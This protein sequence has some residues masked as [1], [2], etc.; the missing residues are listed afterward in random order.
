MLPSTCTWLRRII[1]NCPNLYSFMFI[2]IFTLF[3]LQIIASIATKR[4]KV[5]ACSL[6]FQASLWM[7]SCK[8]MASLITW[9]QGKSRHR[10]ESS[11]KFRLGQLTWREIFLCFGI[12]PSRMFLSK[13]NHRLF[14]GRATSARARALSLSLSVWLQLNW[15]LPFQ[16]SLVLG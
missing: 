6:T 3:F 4:V 9:V 7:C 12:Y 13:Q 1:K 2:F 16:K 8:L 15:P 5:A 11:S 14:V 10:S